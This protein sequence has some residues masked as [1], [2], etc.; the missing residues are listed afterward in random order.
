MGKNTNR[1]GCERVIFSLPK[2]LAAELRKYADAC[3]GGNRSGFVADAV[4][5][6]IKSLRRHRHTAKLRASY[7]QAAQ[8]SLSIS[9][10][11]RYL[12]EEAWGK[13]DR[14]TAKKK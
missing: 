5:A 3:R 14:P 9:E 6:Y 1:T 2:P 12:D 8:H 11:F 13:L 10:D 4:R 7:A